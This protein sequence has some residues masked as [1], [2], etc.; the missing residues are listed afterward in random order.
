M[1]GWPIAKD[2]RI[3]V[4]SAN[5]RSVTDF[6][7]L[8][9]TTFFF[10][11]FLFL[12]A[13]DF[14]FP[15][16]YCYTFSPIL[17]FPFLYLLQHHFFL[18]SSSSA[19]TTTFFFLDPFYFFSTF[20][21]SFFSFIIFSRSYPPSAPS[22]HSL[23]SALSPSFPHSPF[24]PTR[25]PFLLTHSPFLPTHSPLSYPSSHSLLPSSHSFLSP[26]LPSRAFAILGMAVNA[27]SMVFQ[28]Q[29][30]RSTHVD[31]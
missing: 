1:Y 22:S 6:F 15:T 8:H 2:A 10:L 14:S 3:D 28:K 19:A 9:V 25:S 24:L 21:S 13:H 18:F 31:Y 12:F 7:L 5:N 27:E 30:K 20:H 4:I 17:L 16:T 11:F 29:K 26:S 23:L